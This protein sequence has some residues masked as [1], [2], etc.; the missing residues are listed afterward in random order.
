MA[1]VP[2]ICTSC[3][4]VRACVSGQLFHTLECMC[5]GIKKQHSR[6]GTGDCKAVQHRHVFGMNEHQV[7]WGGIEQVETGGN[8]NNEVM[9]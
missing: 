3:C 7:S 9:E 8:I 5:L 1:S 2:A 4:D 6:W